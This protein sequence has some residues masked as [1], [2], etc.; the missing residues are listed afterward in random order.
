MNKIAIIPARAGSKGLKDKNVLNLCGRPLMAWTINAAVESGI[1]DRVIVSTDSQQYGDIVKSYGAEVIYRGEAQSND[2]AST[3][4]VLKDL[5]EKIDT[6]NIDYFMLLQPTSPFRNAEHIMEAAKQFENNADKYDTLVSVCEASKSS[7]LINQI[8]DTL[9]LKSFDTDF[10]AYRRQNFK[11]YE[12]NGAI[13]ISKI[14]T[15][16]ERKHFFGKQGMAYIMD[17]DSS[18]D[19]DCR[20]DF[21]LA[22]NI[23]DRRRKREVAL[24]M[25]KN[26]I[27]QKDNI[28]KAAESNDGNSV[29]LI[30]D[31]LIDGWEI[32]EINGK[33][34]YNLGI[35][36]ISS[37][38]YMEYILK[39]YD[40]NFRDNTVVIMMGTND[41]TFKDEKS[42]LNDMKAVIDNI[43]SKK[44]AKVL[45]IAV[46]NVNGRID[47]N[48]DIINSLNKCLIE[49]LKDF[50][51]II[52]P[53]FMNDKYGWLNAE[54][55]YDGLHFNKKGYEV[56]THHIQ[57]ALR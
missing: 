11:E 15:Y 13:F 42:V 57:E 52:I 35:G 9:S 48:N 4:D 31:S 50:C 16:L 26:R 45:Y 56:L 53:D 28:F 10:S 33:K 29:L 21:E 3:F 17:R 18:I 14:N 44:P 41:M 34:T 54:Y 47:R 20:N 49:G 32:S 37:D 46:S 23:V 1:F 24:D 8:D 51:E 2:K 55:T 19:I 40:I 5:F 38:M 30:G 25:V 36:G 39:H 6:R 12:P 22:I 43:I 7:V 27:E